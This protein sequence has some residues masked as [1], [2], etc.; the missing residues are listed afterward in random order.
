MQYRSQEILSVFA[1]ALCR[2]LWYTEFRV[3]SE[4]DL[5]SGVKEG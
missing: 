4:R 5:P 2:E 3:R 1:A